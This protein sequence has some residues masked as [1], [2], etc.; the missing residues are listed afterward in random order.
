MKIGVYFCNCGGNI[1]DKV[2]SA[3]VRQIIETR[4]GAAYFKTCELMCSDDGKAYLR[5]EIAAEKPDR[6]VIAACSPRDH[7]GT[8]MRVLAGAGM[9]PYLMQMVNI[10]EQVAW[11]TPDIG[12]ASEKAARLIKGAIKRV[13]FHRA[14]EKKSIEMS[15]DVLVI[16]AG[17]AG[18]KAA[19]TIA[20][21]GRK[22]A[23]VEKRPV[24]GGQPVLYEEVFPNL[25]CAP[26]ML[27][28]LLDDILHGEYSEN[29]E[30]L[31]LSKVVELTGFY[32][33]FIAKIKKTPRY[34]D[35][36]QCIGC[37]ECVGVC[38][39]DVRNE[40]N[41]GLDRRKAI[42]L[43]FAGALPNVPF[44]DMP[45]CLRARG[46]DCRLCEQACP[47]GEGI[48]Q[49]DDTEETIERHIGAVVVA[50]GASLYDAGLI[51]KLGHGTVPDVYTSFEFERMLSSTGPTGGQLT[52]RSG[53]TPGSI[54]IVHCV[55]SLD[56]NHKEYC[57]G[58]CCQY[59]F[60]FNLMVG[61]R[62]PDTQI[63]HLYRELVYPGKEEFFLHK[64]AKENPNAAFIRYRNIDSLEITAEGDGVVI[65]NTLSETGSVRADMVVLCPA[66]SPAEDTGK[67]NG[68]LG[69][70]ADTYGFF[71]ELHGRLDAAR[72]TVRGIY[73]AGACQWPMNIQQ[74]MTQGM[75]AAGYVLSG[76]VEGKRLDIE[77][78]TAYVDTERCSGCRVCML[79]C[80]YR[81]IVYDKEGGGK[82]SVNDVLCQGCG[83]CV[84]ACPAGAIGGHHFTNEAI[85]AEIEGLLA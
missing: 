61:H 38:P 67:L 68:V 6:I 37:G 75:A 65:R 41:G 53:Q 4:G 69:T 25:E 83:T 3:Q 12:K 63:H 44:I 34:A 64:R 7:E 43:S 24:I 55:G 84:A 31:T 23:L 21:T 85:F 40:F 59:A 35:V 42:S 78:I 73:I 48:I 66:M 33:N 22:A 15:P 71:E 47:L 8:F 81:A 19:L 62:L 18:L 1:S 58:V 10:R 29:I 27:E 16:G 70:T 45:E 57:S 30:L 74:T 28:P 20:T 26:C 5:D 80:P 52:T 49:Y 13:A 46:E 17:P 9:N 36:H 14:L 82:A 51:P 76:L 39:V 77:P 56:V 72:S 32:G 50:V 54:A 2:D 11:V 60:K 79:L